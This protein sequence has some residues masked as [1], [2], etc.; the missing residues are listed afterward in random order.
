MDFS[1]SEEQQMLATTARDFL[2]K[3][4]PKSLV[5]EMAADERGYPVELWQEMAQ[6][7]WIGLAFPDRYGGMGGSFLDLIIL[8]EEMGRACLPGPFFSTVVLGGLTILDAGSEEQKNAI[9]P[10]VT[11]GDIILTMAFLE[12]DARYEM[13]SIETSASQDGTDYTVNGIKLFVENAHIANYI[14]TPVRTQDGVMALLLMDARSPGIT[15]TLLHTEVGDKQCEVIFNNVRVPRQNIIGKPDKGE[16]YVIRAL[17]RA[18]V[19]KCA[20]M[21]GGG[22]QVMEMTAAYAKERIQFDHPI[23]SLINIQQKFADL[24]IAIES[25]TFISHKAAWMM[26]EG[27]PCAEEISIAKAFVSDAYR[28]AC[29]ISHQ[30]HGTVGFMLEHDLPLYTTR[31]KEAEIAFGDAQ[32]HR[33]IVAQELIT[34][35]NS[36]KPVSTIILE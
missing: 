32:F 2:S 4:C 30:I 24:A 1:L 31:A 10:M 36:G 21:V 8:L 26:S 14:L 17:Q 3:E 6:M 16:N 18:A 35:L 5:K 29:A 34:N 19:A 33:N 27:L 23:G 11:R 7:G 20:E 25:S 22:S 28:S 15:T 12:A 13:D 9:L